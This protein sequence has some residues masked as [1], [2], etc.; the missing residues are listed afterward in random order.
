MTVS[1]RGYPAGAPLLVE[2]F[3]DPVLLTS[4]TADAEGG[5]QIVVTVPPGARPGPAMLR[6]SVQGGIERAET[7]LRVVA[8]PPPLG[9]LDG[10]TRSIL[11]VLGLGLVRP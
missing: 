7:T 8:P 3:T 10:L 6:V 9:L 1:G 4:T 2:L 5:F 11:D